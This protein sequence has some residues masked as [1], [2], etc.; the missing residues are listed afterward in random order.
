MF[1]LAS[2]C[3]QVCRSGKLKHGVSA[4]DGDED[5]RL[6]HL[7][8]L[9][10]GRELCRMRRCPA[11]ARIVATGGK[12]ND[13]QVWDLTGGCSEPAFAAKNVRPD[14]LELRVP[15]WVTDVC[16]PVHG[17]SQLVASALR[18]GTGVPARAGFRLGCKA[19]SVIGSKLLSVFYHG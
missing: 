17:S 13:V 12:E 5:A 18:D 6:K 19:E 4:F 14:N 3:F 9:K 16:F 2:P 10:A 15:V 11:D 8:T 1:R 7:A